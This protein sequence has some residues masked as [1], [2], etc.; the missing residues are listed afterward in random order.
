MAWP[1]LETEQ[2]A[3]EQMI[4]VHVSDGAHIQRTTP[5]AKPRGKLQS[6]R[7][8]PANQRA[9]SVLITISWAKIENCPQ[10]PCGAVPCA[11]PALDDFQALSHPSHILQ[12]GKRSFSVSIIGLLKDKTLFTN[13]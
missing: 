1:R 13:P 7:R 10:R 9:K 11:G 4:H 5:Q 6:P 12:H 8:G 2:D 3:E